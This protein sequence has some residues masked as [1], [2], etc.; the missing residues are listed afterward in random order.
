MDQGVGDV[1]VSRTIKTWSQE[2]SMLLFYIRKT[3]KKKDN[4]KVQ[5][6]YKPSQE[7][8]LRFFK[9]L[10]MLISEKDL[11]E[12]FKQHKKSQKPERVSKKEQIKRNIHPPLEYLTLSSTIDKSFSKGL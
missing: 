1:Y 11:L 10:S 2:S 9:A 7:N 12:Y 5:L 3:K 6:I 4:I 8:S